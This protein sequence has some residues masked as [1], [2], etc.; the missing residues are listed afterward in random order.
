M[1]QKKL[2]KMYC[3]AIFLLLLLCGNAVNAQIKSISG[4]VTLIRYNL[5]T[6][7][8]RVEYK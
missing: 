4:V 7:P 8:N 6:K 1:M 2:K 5:C 3:P